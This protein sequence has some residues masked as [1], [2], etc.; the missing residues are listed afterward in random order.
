MGVV[1][2]M[3]TQLY[4]DLCGKVIDEHDNCIVLEDNVNN[5]SYYFCS[6]KC[7]SIFKLDDQS[8][9]TQHCYFKRAYKVIQD[10]QWKYYHSHGEL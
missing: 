10:W 8:L 3:T 9:R 4:C 1:R 7:E 2:E 5:K 6:I